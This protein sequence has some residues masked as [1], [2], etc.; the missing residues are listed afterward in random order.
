MRTRLLIAIAW[1][2]LPTALFPV[3]GCGGNRA[4][5]ETR[6]LAQSYETYVMTRTGEDK[7]P[8]WTSKK[9]F[10]E[11]DKGLHF[12]GG[13]VG[14][15]DYAVTVRLAKSEAT[16]NLL[17]S[18]EIKTRGEFSTAMHGENRNPEDLGR[19]VTDAV[20]W[21]VENLRIRGIHQK[22]IYYEQ[23]LDPMSQ[24][25][26]YN[27]WVQVQISKP[28][29]VKAKVDAARRLLNK[30]IQEKDED[31]KEKALELLKKL[32]EEA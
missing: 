11:D 5:K 15:A 13:H 21:V 17:E 22:E 27:A 3:C 9:A 24:E 8:D 29:Y 1:A 12:T 18:I 31:A 6:K 2:I 28:D 30:T 32:E 19:Y 25:I 26:K 23:V 16:K 20:A 10:I 4:L 14:G 7:R